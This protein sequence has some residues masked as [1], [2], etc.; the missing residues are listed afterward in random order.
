MWVQFEPSLVRVAVKVS[1][2]EIYVAQNILANPGGNV[3]AAITDRAAKQQGDYVLK[4]LTFSVGT[5]ILAGTFVKLTRPASLGETEQTFYQYDLEYPLN[6]PPPAEVTILNDML[7][8][9]PYAPGTAWA[10]SYVIRAKRLN[11]GTATSWLLGYQQPA[12][13]PTGWDRPM[14]PAVTGAKSQNWRTFCEYLWHG[15]THIL[16]GW[17]HLLFV[18]ALVIATKSF[19]EMVKV[20]RRL[21]WRIPSPSRFACSAF[22]VYPRLSLSR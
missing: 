11:A 17:D 22:S 14:A 10:V 5:N 4:H 7:K 3:E 1:L 9:H 6:G 21:R 12:T 13:I 2:K 19:W 20:I 8:E 16:M 15:I 18:S